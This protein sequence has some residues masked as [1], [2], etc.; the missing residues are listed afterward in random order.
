MSKSIYPGEHAGP[1]WN[2]IYRLIGIVRESRKN[3]VELIEKFDEVKKEYKRIRAKKKREELAIQY[4][5]LEN[6][7]YKQGYIAIVFAAVV[8]EA[9]IS[10]ACARHKGDG[11]TKKY[12][13]RLSI[14]KKW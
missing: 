8:I 14:K 6:E 4:I 5:D 1:R 13:D 11:F 2:A 10:D 7:V 9:Q 3:F 12:I